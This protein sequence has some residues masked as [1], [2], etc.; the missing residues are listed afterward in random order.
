LPKAKTPKLKVFQA[1]FGFFDTVIA[2]PSQAAALRAWGTHSNLFATGHARLAI[3][4]AAIAAALE[5]PGTLLR[6]AV[7]SND[8]FRVEPTSLPKA[9]ELAAAMPELASTPKAKPNEKPEPRPQPVR[10]PPPDRS[11]LD[12]AERAL[13]ELDK[14][15]AR[16]EA[17]LRRQQEQLDAKR[18]AAQH[19][20]AEA[21]KR[22]TAAVIS[23][24]EAYRKA[25]GAE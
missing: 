2:V 11:R 17:D 3:D 24:R 20:Y 10:K 8:P 9:P 4:Q 5:R 1:Q 22:A 14:Q 6:R 7:G 21:W 25:G 13:Q 19:T 15:H 18:I 23:A 12:A 16:E